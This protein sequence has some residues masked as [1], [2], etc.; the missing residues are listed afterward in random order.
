MT[1]ETLRVLMQAIAP[2]LREMAQEAV[3]DVTERLAVVEAHAPRLMRAEANLDALTG[4]MG[5][6]RERIAVMETRPVEPGPPG[7]PGP[8]G[9]NGIDGKAGLT[10]CGVYQDGKTYEPGEIVT[11]AGST[12]HCHA[13]TTSKPGEGATAWT[14]MVKRGRDGKDGKP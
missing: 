14:L 4:I 11:W 5:T 10:Y 9:A 3:Q 12:W 2:V 13:A 6:V 7:P 1:A 8:A